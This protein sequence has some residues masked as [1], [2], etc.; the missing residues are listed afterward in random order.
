MIHVIMDAISYSVEDSAGTF[1]IGEDTHWSGSPSH[2]PEVLLQHIGGANLFPELFG[3]GI[4]MET[5]VK[6]LLH[7]SDRSYRRLLQIDRKLCLPLQ[8]QK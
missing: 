3:K 2:F 1:I 6:V 7:T 4:V 8:L 5:V